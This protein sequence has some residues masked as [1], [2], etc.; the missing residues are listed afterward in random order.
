MKIT[1]A[2]GAYSANDVSQ[3]LAINRLPEDPPFSIYGLLKDHR[4]DVMK[5][6]LTALLLW[7]EMVPKTAARQIRE[8][9]IEAL[10][11]YV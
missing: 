2:T 3:T 7:E 10:Q 1:P 6:A 4:D 8:E 9:A 11:K 5:K